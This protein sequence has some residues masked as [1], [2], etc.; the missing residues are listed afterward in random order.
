MSSK[1]AYFPSP[2]DNGNDARRQSR[3]KISIRKS[4]NRSLGRATERAH[5][6]RPQAV[7]PVSLLFGAIAIAVV[8]YPCRTWV[9][10]AHKD[11][12]FAEI[13]TRAH[14]KSRAS[15]QLVL[16]YTFRSALIRIGHQGQSICTSSTR[17]YL[18]NS[19]IT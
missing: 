7:F 5:R 18:G 8:K 12:G 16:L 15:R 3:S 9:P 13:Y 10:R 4:I 2:R 6:H 17:L 1:K 11:T 19:G 14:A